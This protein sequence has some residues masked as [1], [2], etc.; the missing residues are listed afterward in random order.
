[1][2]WRDTKKS[3]ETLKR[4]AAISYSEFLTTDPQFYYIKEKRKP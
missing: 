2:Q 1:V 4:R 3:E